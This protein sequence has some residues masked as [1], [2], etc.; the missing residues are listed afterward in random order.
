MMHV[1]LKTI[2]SVLLI[3]L[4][5]LVGSAQERLPGVFTYQGRAFQS[6]GTTPLTGT[7]TFSVQIR[8]ADGNCLIYE[9]THSGVDLTSSVGFFALNV[10]DGT[11]SSGLGLSDA[12]SNLAANK[13]TLSGTCGG[14]YSPLNQ[15]SRVLRVTVDVGGGPISLDDQYI[16]TVP[17]AL[18]ADTLNGFKYDQFVQS[19]TT[20][21]R[22]ALTAM[23]NGTT[24]Y[25]I[26]TGRFDR[27]NG[28]TWGEAFG[29]T[30]IGAGA[31]IYSSK[32]AGN[33]WLQ[34]RSIVGASGVTATQNASDITLSIDST[35]TQR[36]VTGTCS[37]GNFIT[38]V[39][40]DGTVTCAADASGTGTVTSVTAGDTTVTIGGTAADP[41]V[42]VSEANLDLD[43]IGGIL[44]YDQ[45]ANC[46]ADQ[47]LQQNGSGTGWT[48][49]AQVVDTDTTY[50]AGSGLDLTGTTFSIP[51]DGVVNTMIA[52][53]AIDSL[54]QLAAMGCTGNQVLQ[55]N[56]G[57]T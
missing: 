54:A 48:C 23:V 52:D 43:A 15:D 28:A 53:G 47:I 8:S 16:Y 9:E 10:G 29:A 18:V 14:V 51:A 34:L 46:G 1:N 30:N 44:G 55:R 25:N 11:A 7:A 3:L 27:Y 24:I 22:D 6:D 40:S 41:T 56:A 39:N 4:F 49:V 50:S 35:Y 57:N 26:T 5:S 38:G 19:L 32:L 20:T 42:A 21:Q 2:L 17:Q 37:A 36:R 13:A 33:D 31:Q 12:F 45:L